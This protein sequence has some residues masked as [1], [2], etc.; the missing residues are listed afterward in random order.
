MCGMAE[1]LSFAGETPVAVPVAGGSTPAPAVRTPQQWR[2]V[3]V[4]NV[5]CSGVPGAGPL[6]TGPLPPHSCA[7]G[8]SRRQGRVWQLRLADAHEAISC[9][10]R[11]QTLQRMMV[12][13]IT[14]PERP[15]GFASTRDVGMCWAREL[16]VAEPRWGCLRGPALVDPT[17]A[18]V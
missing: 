5:V 10:A 15:R 11:L 13:G 9:R 6:A 14:M 7:V 2:D 8:R 16:A 1:P 4:R 17:A 18:A 12:G 3:L